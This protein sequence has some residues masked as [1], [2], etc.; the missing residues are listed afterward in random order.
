MR[1]VNSSARAAVCVCVCVCV[2]ASIREN[3]FQRAATDLCDVV[4][5]EKTLAKL[6]VQRKAAG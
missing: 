6:R 3:S 5:A 1:A 2:C 4:R